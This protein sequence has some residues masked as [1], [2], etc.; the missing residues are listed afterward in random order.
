MTI[1]SAF[2]ARRADIMVAPGISAF[3]AAS[4][5]AGAPF[6]HDFCA[7]SLSN[8]LTPW[9]VIE[10]RL[11][12]AAEGDFVIA[13]YNPV[14]KRRRWQIEV[15][16]DILLQHRPPE[17]PVIIASNLG[18]NSEKITHV[19]LKDL[20][21]DLV[22]MLTLVI[23][24]SSE[25]RRIESG[26]GKQFVYTPRGYRQKTDQNTEQKTQESAAQ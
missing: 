15:A 23:V 11:K 22:D 1:R 13:F 10:N 25:T 2:S 17:T 4:A 6:G 3:Q 14:S 21:P 16:R 18:R 9:E 19:A 7:I 26:S 5:R 20:V 8:L 12:S 24:G